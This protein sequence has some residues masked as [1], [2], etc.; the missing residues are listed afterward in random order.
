[1]TFWGSEMG[2]GDSKPATAPQQQPQ[3]APP[4][5]PPTAPSLIRAAV[6]AG[7]VATLRDPSS[8]ARPSSVCGACSCGVQRLLRW[9][10]DRDPLS[11]PTGTLW[12]LA[13]R[14]VPR[15]CASCLRAAMMPSSL[16]CP[17]PWACRGLRSVGSSVSSHQGTI[18]T[19]AGTS[20]LSSPAWRPAAIW[21]NCGGCCVFL[22]WLPQHADR[23]M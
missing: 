9:N 1:M 12:W 23:C 11:D 5:V 18:F 13:C 14:R 6:L 3:R 7:M 8:D 4:P 10:G 2:A 17:R 16:Y 19:L 22:A 20:T 21:W 15:T